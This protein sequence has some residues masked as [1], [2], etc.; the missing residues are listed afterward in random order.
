MPRR[1]FRVVPDRST[2]VIAATSTIHPIRT[3]TAG[4]EGY[5]DLAFRRGRIDAGEDADGLLALP[6]SKLSSGNPLQD[7]ELRRRIDARRFPTITGRLTALE[8]GEGDGRFR[9][10][11]ELTFRGVT[12]ECADELAIALDRSTLLVSG[13]SRFDIRDFGMA[14]PSILLARVHPHVDVTIDLHCEQDGSA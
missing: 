4:L 7:R 13:S 2:V 3:R 10:R 5:V 1:R 12:R 14:P 6:V 11:G 9:A 8:A